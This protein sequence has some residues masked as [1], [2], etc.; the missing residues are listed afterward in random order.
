M[1]S[2]LVSP[3]SGGLGSGAFD[4]TSNKDDYELLS[5]IGRGATASVYAARYKP[6]AEKVA[7]KCIDLEKYG[8]NIE[9]I[10]KEIQVMSQCHHENVVT[11]YTSFVVKEELWLVMRLLDGGSALEIMKF[12]CPKGYDEVLIASILKE[13]LLGLAYFHKNGQIHRD[14]KAGNILLDSDGTVQLA[15]FGVSSWLVEGGERRNHRQ[16]FVGTPCWMAPEVMEQVNG[17]D[18]KADIWSFGITA[19]ELAT[20]HAPFAKYS[21]M[22]VLMLTLQNPPPSLD[23]DGQHSRYTKTFKKMIDVCL[24]KDPSK[25]P[26]ATELLKHEFF[27]KARGKDYIE[28]NLLAKLPPIEKRATAKS[29]AA[30]AEDV[31]AAPGGMRKGESGRY[32]KNESGEWDFEPCSDEEESDDEE[33]DLP[34]LDDQGRAQP[35]KPSTKAALRAAKIAE[36]ESDEEPATP[37][38]VSSPGGPQSGTSSSSEGVNAQAAAQAVADAWQTA[39]VVD[40]KIRLR[41]RNRQLKDIRFSFARNDDT[42][43]QIAKELVEANLIEAADEKVVAENIAII[44]NVA[45]RKTS[46]KFMLAEAA[47]LPTV[48]QEGLHGYAQVLLC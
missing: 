8:A 33:I 26:P 41:D 40:L 17:Y 1:T 35:V 18:Y 44:T 24:Q 34:E 32:R 21:P 4:Y 48:D 46:L 5:V 12:F 39:V 31:A 25:R 45:N 36:D 29:K 27:K 42:V 23:L 7:I 9:E 37:T 15:D 43:E 2:P 6:R 38:A 47:T 22:K 16:T 3:T 19:I 28:A 10:R 14:V 13:V 11:Y 30:P 20:G